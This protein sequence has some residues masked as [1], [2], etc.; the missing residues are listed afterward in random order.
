MILK[1][2]NVLLEERLKV[3]HSMLRSGCEIL[4]KLDIEKSYN[5][6]NWKFLLEL[7][8]KMVLG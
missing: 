5:H 3:I 1:L 6:I 4:C 2:K 7:L 8:H